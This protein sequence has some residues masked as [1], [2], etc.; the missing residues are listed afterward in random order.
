L[1]T[2]TGGTKSNNKIEAVISDSTTLWN[3]ANAGSMSTYT[4]R[5]TSATGTAFTGG[6][7]ALTETWDVVLS[8]G[9][10]IT[11]KNQFGYVGFGG[12]AVSG[13]SISAYGS[14]T[15]GSVEATNTHAIKGSSTLLADSASAALTVTQTG[16]GNA[17]VVEDSATTDSTPFIV[18]SIGRVGVGDCELVNDRLAVDS[19][20][21]RGLRVLSLFRWD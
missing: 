9:G 1:R 14:T 20:V 21:L 18:D 11:Y 7:A 4:V 19:S 10:T 16:S 2:Y 8:I 12:A 15:L 17:L 3:H 5:G 6:E 13:V